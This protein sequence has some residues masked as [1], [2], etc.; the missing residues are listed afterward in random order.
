MIVGIADTHTAIWQLF[1]DDRLGKAASAFLDLT[2]NDGDQIG[3]SAI[4]LAE[5]VYLIEK[6]SIPRI[7]LE[8][9]LAA[10]PQ[11]SVPLKVTRFG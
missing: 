5:I 8:D 3:W 10:I 7:A 6:N 1:S 11:R 4:S 9:I 2:N